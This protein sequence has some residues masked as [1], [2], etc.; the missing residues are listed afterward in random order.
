MQTVDNFKNLLPQKA[1]EDRQCE[2]RNEVE[3]QQVHEW[4]LQRLGRD[5]PSN[6]PNG[7]VPDTGGV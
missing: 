1:V 7:A 2:F 5:L 6:I 4:L 3:K